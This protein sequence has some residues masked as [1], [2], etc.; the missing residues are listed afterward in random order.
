LIIITSM[1]SACVTGP[2][3]YLKRSAN[4]KLFDM[5]GFEGG[6]RSPLY[7]KK[8][9][10][11]AKKNILT[12][13]LDEDMEEDKDD[14]YEDE[15]PS[16]ENIE[17]YKAMIAADIE[18]KNKRNK[19]SSWWG[20]NK[21]KAQSYPSVADAKDSIDPKTHAQNLELKEELEQIK[22]MLNE[23]KKEM[24]SYK[25]PTAQEQEKAIKNEN[26][27]KQPILDRTNLESSEQ[28]TK[29]I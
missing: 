23:T 9:I 8:Y 21:K 4:N 18:R 11:Q 24:A 17:M 27:A 22:A 14:L 29:E 1:L 12:N 13:N 20:N 2:D 25:C 6:K 10:S 7:N 15:N 19:K 26:Q 3:G 5:H 28:K 16:Q